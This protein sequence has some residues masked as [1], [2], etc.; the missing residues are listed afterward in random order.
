MKIEIEKFIEESIGKIPKEP[1]KFYNPE[2][3]NPSKAL[4]VTS[5]E[6]TELFTRIDFH[7]QSSRMYINGGWIQ[8][9][10]G[11][12]IQPVNTSQN[13]GLVQTIGI[14][15]AP[16]KHYFNRQGED[17]AYSL[18]FPALPKNNKKINIIENDNP[19]SYFNFY[20]IDYSNWMTV[21]TDSLLGDGLEKEE[22]REEIVNRIK[23]YLGRVSA[24][25]PKAEPDAEIPNKLGKPKTV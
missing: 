25:A 15:M 10:G 4:R 9:N 2:R 13:Y 22:S 24:P 12:Y 14:P 6:A 18:I 17:Y 3:Q 1:Q 16:L 21:P 7:Y 19:G 20:G 5:I 8:I 11:A 23:G